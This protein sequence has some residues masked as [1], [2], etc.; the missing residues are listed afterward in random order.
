MPRIR[1][2]QRRTGRHQ[3]DLADDQVTRRSVWTYGVDRTVE[4]WYM[5]LV[6]FVYQSLPS[7]VWVFTI[8]PDCSRPPSSS[9]GSPSR[10]GIS[11]EGTVYAKRLCDEGKVSGRWMRVASGRFSPAAQ[12]TDRYSEYPMRHL[13]HISTYLSKH[14]NDG[15]FQAASLLISSQLRRRHLSSDRAI[16]RRRP[17]R[18]KY[19]VDDDWLS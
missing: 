7:H 14:A 19:L 6:S 16:G 9:I 4:S 2:H 5:P 17:S 1:E 13:L 11:F 12:A 10:A 15:S 18:Q 8:C 3:F